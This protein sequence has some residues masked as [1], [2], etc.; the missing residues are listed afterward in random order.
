MTVSV[1]AAVVFCAVGE[2]L[3][4]PL[5]TALVASVVYVRGDVKILIPL[6]E[7]AETEPPM[8]QAMLIKIAPAE[9]IR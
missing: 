8:A 2:G 9:I 3:G 1:P 6:R 5:G 7:I 4:T